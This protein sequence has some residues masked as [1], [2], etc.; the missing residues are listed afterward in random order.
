MSVNQRIIELEKNAKERGISSF[1]KYIDVPSSTFANV[2]G[3]RLSEPK[4][5]LLIK[6]LNAFPDLSLEW[7]ILGKGDMFKIKTST[8]RVIDYEGRIKDLEEKMALL[9]NDKLE[10]LKD[11]G[12]MKAI[13]GKLSEKI[14]KRK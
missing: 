9:M 1:A 5:S 2:T 3:G 10:A 14:E 11:Y 7:L 13:V 8:V 4:H 12:E 6:I